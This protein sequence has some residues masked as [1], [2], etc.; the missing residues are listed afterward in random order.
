NFAIAGRPIGKNFHSVALGVDGA[1]L[2]GTG[3][4]IS[5]L[6]ESLSGQMHGPVIDKTALDGKYDYDVLF[7]RENKPD[8]Q[9][10]S[11]PAAIQSLGLKLERS[12]AP[13]EVLVVD[14]IEKPSQN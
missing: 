12:K 2:M 10:P 7:A 9:A 1:H 13:V 8:D 11:L 6:A 5:Q 3:A 14:H 4:T